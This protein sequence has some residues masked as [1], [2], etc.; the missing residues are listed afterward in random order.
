M[1]SWYGPG[2]NGRRTANGEI[3]NQE[4]LTAASPTLPLGTLVAVTNLNNGRSVLVRINDRG[5]FL[6]GRAIDLSHG[7]ARAL[8]MVGQGTAPVKIE[9]VRGPVEEASVAN[10][11]GYYIQVGSF[12]NLA[13]ALRLR[14]R[15]A[16]VYPNVKIEEL[17]AGTSHYYRVR[18]GGFA[19]RAQ[20]LARAKET[21]SLKMPL[22]IGR[23]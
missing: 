7:A 11:Y 21:L 14:D 23:E 22:I 3:Y 17:R 16:S 1:A 12:T 19:S 15:L 6:K 13:N 18:I 4:D 8:G 5:P 9:V 2:F 20:A 10:R